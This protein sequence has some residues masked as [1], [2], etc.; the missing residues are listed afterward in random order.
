LA[1][2]AAAVRRFGDN[3]LELLEAARRQIER[4]AKVFLTTASSILESEIM[5][6]SRA[7][8]PRPGALTAWQIA[9]VSAFIDENLHRTIHAKDLSAVA[10]RSTSHSRGLSNKLSESH[11]TR[12]W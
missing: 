1:N 4:E 6:G 3:V 9:C 2:R 7:N 10:Q 5:C 11:R 8:S 12:T